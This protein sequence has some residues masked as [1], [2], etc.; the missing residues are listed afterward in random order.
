[1]HKSPKY[2]DVATGLIAI[3]TSP[4]DATKHRRGTVSVH[5]LHYITKIM[6]AEDYLNIIDNLFDSGHS[7]QAILIAIHTPS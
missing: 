3:C 2:H 6:N 1:V 5:G 4:Y 7:V